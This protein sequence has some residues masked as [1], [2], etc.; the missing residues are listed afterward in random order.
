M[1]DGGVP[2]TADPAALPGA[3]EEAHGEQAPKQDSV[4]VPAESEEEAAERTHQEWLRQLTAKTIAAAAAGSSFS[5]TDDDGAIRH[6]HVRNNGEMRRM[7]G[8]KEVGP[9]LAAIDT[10]PGRTAWETAFLLAPV[11]G[12]PRGSAP[13]CVYRSTN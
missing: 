13:F 2:A 9:Q 8:G 11:P 4:P 10:W 1:G 3:A 12:V 7:E 5:V 6:Y